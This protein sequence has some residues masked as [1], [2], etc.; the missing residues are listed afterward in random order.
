MKIDQKKRTFSFNNFQFDAKRTENGVVEFWVK[1]KVD[2]AKAMGHIHAHDRMMQLMLVR[3]IGQGRL[4]ELLKSDDDT[5]I[6][7]KFMREMSFYH[8]AKKEVQNLSDDVRKFGESYCEGINAY[9]DN[10]KRPFEFVLAGLKP[11]PWK[12]EDTL[13]TIKLMSYM[14]LAQ[15]QQEI[16]KLILQMVQ[17]DAPIGKLKSLF[18]PHL[19]HFTDD[20]IALV[21]KAHIYQNP[22]PDNIK[23]MAAVP[24]VLA[25]NNWV[26]SPEKSKSGNALQCNDPHLEVNRLPAIWYEFIAHTEDNYY[27]GVNMPGV[28]G[29]VMGRNKNVSYGFTYGFMDLVDY[30][31]DEIKDGHFKDEDTLTE[32]TVREELIRRKGKDS[33]PLY[34]RESKNGVIEYDSE[35]KLKDGLYLTR[36]WSGHKNGALGSLNALYN[37]HDV[38]SVKEGQKA[39]QEITISCN[40]LF[41]DKEG[42]IGYQQSGRFPH[43]QHSGLHPL[44]G[45]K[46]ENRWQDVRPGSDLASIFNPKEG[47]IATA[48]NDM[49]EE[50]KPLSINMPMGSYR[51]DRVK[52]LLESQEKFDIKDMKKYQSDLL[53]TQARSFIKEITPL[54]KDEENEAANILK[55]WDLCYDKKSQGSVVFEHFY[56]RLF[57]IMYGRDFIGSEAWDYIQN[58]TNTIIDFYACF[59]DIFIKT[60]DEHTKLWFNKKSK[61]EYYKEALKLTYDHFKN[62]K[63]QTWGDIRKVKMNNLFFDGKLPS[64]LG[65]DYGPISLEGNRATIVQGALYESH[66]RT[67]TFCPSFRYITD[68]GID[69]THTVLAGGVRD[70]RFSKYYTSDVENWLNYRYKTLKPS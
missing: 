17:K 16:E 43:R 67:L 47:F 70:R 39:A 10:N 59:D 14:G 66:G 1:N 31:I 48:N 7:D 62:L 65:F 36:A 53:S 24:K 4:S 61:N 12:I 20:Q 19:D 52:E 22:V 3:V 13:L 57:D 44:E 35:K 18:S 54:L 64:F 21:K 33:V 68:M 11:E 63:I 41:S 55:N 15:T 8:E 25:S 50:G 6:I 56:A 58:Q 51:A 49:N 60:T 32:I 29:V 46:K 34:I 5:L 26:L 38:K 27:M 23:W 28:P 37:I 9:L 42:N 69:E 30:F 2:M 40:W 45:W